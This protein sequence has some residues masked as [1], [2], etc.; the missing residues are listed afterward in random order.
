MNDKTP[1]EMPGV[2]HV[3]EGEG[4]EP[5]KDFTPYTISNRAH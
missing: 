5:S 3:A 2:F 1:G 4:F